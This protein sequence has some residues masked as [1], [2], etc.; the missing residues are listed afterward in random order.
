V[1][2][3]WFLLLAVCSIQQ[4]FAQ[5]V[6]TYHN[7]NARTGQNLNETIL[8]PNNVNF[9][10]FGKLFILAADGKVDAEPLYVSNLTVGSTSHNVVFVASEHDSVYAYDA[11][12]G[13]LLWQV[14]LVK[15]GETPSDDR[16]CAFVTPEIGITATPVIDRSSGPHGTIYLIAMSKDSSGGY[17]QRLHALDITTGA[18]EFGGP[19]DI[20]ATYSGSGAEGN[21]TTLTFDP[22][23]HLARASLLLLNG[24][25][26]VGWSSH[27]DHD[28]YTAWIM[29]YDENTLAQTRLLNITPNGSEGSVW[30]SGAG[31][32]ADS[33]G[34]IYFLTANGTADTTLNAQGF[35]ISGDYGNAFMKLSTG[36]ALAVADYF[37]ES[38]TVSESNADEDLGSGG[39]L[40]LPD[41][42]VN[43]VTWHL[44]VGAGKDSN[45]Y[46]VNRDNMGKFNPNTNNIY[47]QLTT[48]L[49]GQE[50]G[51]AAYFNNAIYYGAVGDNLR[52]FAFANAM[53]QANPAST[54][55]TTFGYPGTTPSISANGSA[56]GIVW[57]TENTNPA[58]LHAYAAGNL[59]TELYNSN[60]APNNADQFGAGNKFITPMIANGKVYVATTTGVGVFGLRGNGGTP[61]VQ[62]TA[63]PSSGAAPLAVNFDATGSSD[64]DGGAL[65]YSWSFGDGTP[66]ATG[67]T[68]THV[69]QNPGVYTAALTVRDGRGGT[70]STTTQ[71]TVSTVPP[72]SQGAAPVIWTSLVNAS[73]TGTVVRKTSGCDGCADSG[74][75]SQQTISSGDGYVEFTVTEPGT[76]RFI[77]LSNGNPGTTPSE[78]KFALNLYSSYIEVRES[79]I[80]KTDRPFTIGDVFRISITAGQVTYSK[81]GTVFYT[82]AAAPAYPLLVDTA[83]LGVNASFSNVVILSGSITPPPP[84]LPVISNVNASAAGTSAAISWNTD[85]P[86]DTQVEYGTTTAY[87]ISTTLN[88]TSVTAH[89]QMLTGLTSKTLYHYR[90]KSGNANGLAIS[91]DSTFITTS[92]S[93][94]A[95]VIWTSLVNAS[96]TGTVLRKT[97]GCDGCADSGAI[98]QQTISSGDGYVEFTVT[99]PGTQR[100]IG[101]SNGNPGTTPSEIKFALN[102]HSPNIE[103]RESGIYKADRPFTIGDVFRISITAGQVTYSK[104]GTVFY[105]SAAVPVYP[106]LVDTALL[107]A[108]ASLTNVLINGN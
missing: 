85:V 61:S 60:Q 20:Q 73:V 51:Q 14:T 100:F 64:P 94:A 17:H 44:A 103:V 54:T 15:S 99:E 34:N 71:I 78:I 8:N 91:G 35:P 13:A 28:P 50:F 46:L 31:L 89:N 26:Y 36:G 47:Q 79:G 27:C 70:A 42:I 22:K 67:V 96:V 12:T 69:Y 80:Y 102:L 63:K 53:L 81:N 66:N 52:M 5:D 16:S 11:D 101:L 6:L 37:N 105:T 25:V 84:S 19:L 104:N 92:G 3:L 108:N 62:L 65:T 98:S 74:A 97:S 72:P 55:I 56:N 82:S 38:N 39:A 48:P 87:G 9:N 88:T 1:R 107:G 18:E 21:G 30:Q 2:T 58:V 49:R 57:A 32:A 24:I 29:G 23:Q 45:I 75:I 43:N 106:L 40:V 77:G 33:S 86:S 90:V 59:G 4:T 10:Q 7:D 83:L 68:L 41:M 95:P 93:T 76:Q